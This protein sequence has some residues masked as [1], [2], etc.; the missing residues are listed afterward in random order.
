MTTKISW[1][2]RLRYNKCVRWLLVR[3][4]FKWEGLLDFLYPD[5]A[6]ITF[7]EIPWSERIN[8]LAVHPDAAN[9]DD[10]ARLASELG[11]CLRLLAIIQNKIQEFQVREI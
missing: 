11:D 6:E 9:R 8:M 5:D 10:V 1:A 7:N 3:V 4:P 2:D